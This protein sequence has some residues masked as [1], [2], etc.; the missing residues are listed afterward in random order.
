MELNKY[1]S[2]AM[3]TCTASS[4]NLVY[5]LNGLTA[6]VGEVNDKV[7]KAVRKELITINNNQMELNDPCFELIDGLRKEI[8][9]VLWF[10]AGLCDTLD[11]S[12]EQIAQ[13]NLAK[14]K[15]RQERGVIIGNGDE[16]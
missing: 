15:S 16:R 11:W 12:L 8:G 4:H 14:L 13:E 10:V 6:E 9:D 7:A 5:M 1:Q 2:E 3:T